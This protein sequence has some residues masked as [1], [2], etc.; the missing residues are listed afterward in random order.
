[1]AEHAELEL[2]GKAAYEFAERHL[3]KLHA[4]SHTWEIEYEDVTTGEKWIMGYSHSEYHGGG[5]PRL[6]KLPVA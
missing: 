6:R 4:N 5:Y 2:E 3:K 1:M